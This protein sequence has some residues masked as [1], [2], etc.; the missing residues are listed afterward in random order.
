MASIFYFEVTEPAKVTLDC[1]D[2]GEDM[3]SDSAA[4][5][6]DIAVTVNEV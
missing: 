4:A 1:W 5:D 6:Q 2:T 3:D